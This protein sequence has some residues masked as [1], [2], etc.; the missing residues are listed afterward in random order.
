MKKVFII[1]ISSHLSITSIVYGE[2]R[3]KHALAV[4][5]KVVKEYYKDNY[6][7]EISEDKLDDIIKAHYYLDIE[8]ETFFSL[9]ERFIQ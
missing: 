2:N 8:N 3:Y 4:F 6:T 1:S 7:G 5:I 9:D